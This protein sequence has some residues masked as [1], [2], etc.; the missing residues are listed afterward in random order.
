MLL[1]FLNLGFMLILRAADKFL[2]MGE[3]APA[4]RLTKDASGICRKVEQ[5]KHQ[6]S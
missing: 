5:N 3:T 6:E 4:I 2:Q 1:I